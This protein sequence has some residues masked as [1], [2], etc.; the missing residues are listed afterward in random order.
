VRH[1]DKHTETQAGQPHR[2]TNIQIPMHT[3]RHRERQTLRQ[4]NIHIYQ[5]KER[6]RDRKTDRQT[7]R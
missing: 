3:E 6:Q 5:E 2:E 1:A 4:T 7:D